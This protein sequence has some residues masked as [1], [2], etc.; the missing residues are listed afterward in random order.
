MGLSDILGIG[1]MRSRIFFI[2]IIFLSVLL[3]FSGLF[4]DLWLDEITSFQII[5]KLSSPIQIFTKLFHDNNHHLNSLYMYLLGVTAPCA[6]V[7]YRLLSFMLGIGAVIL[8]LALT[9][10]IFS[11]KIPGVITLLLMA[12]SFPLV[13]YSSEAR[14]YSM[15]IFFTLSSLYLLLEYCDKKKPWAFILF[16]ISFVLGFLSQPQFIYAASGLFILYSRHLDKKSITPGQRFR[17]LFN[18]FFMPITIALCIYIPF[19]MHLYIGGGGESSAFSVLNRFMAFM[20]GYPENIY[21]GRIITILALVVIANEIKYLIKKNH[22]F[23]VFA[24][25]ISILPVAVLLFRPSQPHFISFRYFVILVPFYIM[26]VSH[27]L[28]RLWD[29]GGWKKILSLV[30]IALVLI[31]NIGR[32]V[33]FS[34]IGRGQYLKA[35]S[36]IYQETN[37]SEIVVSSDHDYRN[38]AM[39]RFYYSFIPKDKKLI[40]VSINSD[41]KKKVEWRIEHSFERN[42]HPA[43]SLR[44]NNATYVLKK[45]YPFNGDISGCHWFIYQRML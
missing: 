16:K 28:Y 18:L 9:K 17:G 38:L 19:I 33:N 45:S 4:H 40:Y 13:V 23:G 26:L 36:Y 21:P 14:G 34:T 43:D 29:K 7:K 8:S 35:L 2:L 3:R 25:G 42:P 30:I 10:K 12:T 37:S 44:L 20:G 1:F 41:S 24:L 31:G 27:A 39:L 32:G 15:V 5:S 11:N 22:D 6:W